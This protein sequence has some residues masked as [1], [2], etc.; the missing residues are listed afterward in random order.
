MNEDPI[1]A[2][3]R[4]VR[5]KLASRFN[6]DIHAIFVDLMAHDRVLDPAHPLV[7]NVSDWIEAKQ[8]AMALND[9]PPLG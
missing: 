7:N 2:E 6:Y 5:D 9:K 1:V 4:C 3:V 8:N